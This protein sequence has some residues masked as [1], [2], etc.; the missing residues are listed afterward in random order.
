[1]REGGLASASH[2]VGDDA[3]ARWLTQDV[4]AAIVSDQPLPN[5]PERVSRRFGFR[6]RPTGA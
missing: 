1:V 3:L 5:R 6:R 4:P 2:A